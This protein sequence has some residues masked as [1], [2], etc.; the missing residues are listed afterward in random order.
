MSWRSVLTDVVFPDKQT[1]LTQRI[2]H[3]SITAIIL[4]ILVSVSVITII[5]YQISLSNNAILPHILNFLIQY[6]IILLSLISGA[7]VGFSLGFIGGGGSILAVPLLLYVVG[8][9]DPHLAIGTSALA[10]SINAGI[11]ILHHIRKRNVI[12]RDGLAFAIP[13]VIGTII[14]SQLGLLTPSGSLIFFFA[15]L[16]LIIAA[17]MYVN[18]PNKKGILQNQGR[19]R[20]LI[21]SNRPVP[22]QITFFTSHKMKVMGLLVGLAA[23]YFG[24]GG[25]FL[26]VPSFL[27]SGLNISNSIGTSLIPVSMFGATTALGYSFENQVNIMISMLFVI[28][29][30]GGGFLGTK[31]LTRIPMSIITNVFATIIGLTGIYIILKIVLT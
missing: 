24:I 5:L 15:L 4:S 20:R 31:L 9:E 28:G 1:I 21:F 2:Q 17:R 29:G 16:M 26:V 10:V 7:I 22:K 3:V 23:G 11:N 27:H 8:I 30:A 14:G 13:G 6:K 12:F 18:K 25:G 19:N